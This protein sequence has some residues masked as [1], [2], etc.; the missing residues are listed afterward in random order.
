MATN[1]AKIRKQR[2]LSQRE[3]AR[4]IGVP[5]QYISNLETGFRNINNIAFQTGVQI[6]AALGVDNLS[7]LLNEDDPIVESR[8]KSTSPLHEPRE[9]TASERERFRKIATESREARKRALAGDGPEPLHPINIPTFKPELLMPERPRLE[10]TAISLFSGGGGL[11]L[12]FDRAGFKHVGSWELLEDAAATLRLNRPNWTVFGGHDGDVREVDWQRFRSN[13]TVVHGG[14]PCQP[15]S[16]AGKQRGALDPRDMWPEFVRCVRE[17]RPEAFVAENV[18]ALTTA[19]FQKYVETV[20]LKPLQGL[21]HIHILQMQAYE[22]GVPQVRRR[23]LFFGFRNRSLEKAWKQPQPTH[24]RPGGSDSHLPETIGVRAALGLPDIGFDD[25]CPTLRSGLS[26]PRHTTS[27]LSSVS[28]QKKYDQLQIWPNGVAANREAAHKFVTKNG[29][30]RL[31][32]PDVALI[33]GFPESWR[34]EGAT[35]MQLG[36]IG[37]S[38]APPVAYRAASS[39]ADLFSR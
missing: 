17:V 6:G 10:A 5:T 35:Y 38:V 33:Q 12:G 11:D 21:Y 36:Q 37:N 20:I 4:I 15:F 18:A 13:V 24:R 14:P 1:L 8:I 9:L 39:V 27:I 3:L 2:G 25:V 32:V 34:F 16:S 30:F 31:S 26:G 22:Y 7:A 23:V 19:R 29:S 28:A